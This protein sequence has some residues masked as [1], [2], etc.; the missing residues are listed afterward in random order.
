[1][2]KSKHCYTRALGQRCVWFHFI[3]AAFVFGVR[4]LEMVSCKASLCLMDQ[5]LWDILGR[6]PQYREYKKW[7]KIFIYLRNMHCAIVSVL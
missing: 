5:K 1:M 3:S 7:H 6:F 2:T 4:V